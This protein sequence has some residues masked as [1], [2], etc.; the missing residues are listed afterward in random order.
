MS[1]GL[2]GGGSFSD[3]RF[4]FGDLGLTLGGEIG[5]RLDLGGFLSGAS[6]GLHVSSDRRLLRGAR[7]G[8]STG[9]RLTIGA[10]G[11]FGVLASGT[12]GFTLLGFISGLRAVFFAGFLDDLSKAAEDELDTATE[13]SLP[14]IT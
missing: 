9:L 14:G 3:L 12:L 8:L 2:G 6:G 1:L 7:T 11:L 4:D 10:G 13:S 5:L